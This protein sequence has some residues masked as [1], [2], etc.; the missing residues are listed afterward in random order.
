M[1][2]I[3]QPFVVT[4]Q[5]QQPVT[6]FVNGSVL[7]VSAISAT[8]K[9]ALSANSTRKK[10]LFHNPNTDAGLNNNLLIYPVKDM[11]GATLAPTFAA[12]GGGFVIFPGA[13]LEVS[14]VGSV[15]TAWSV[16]ASAGTLN[17]LTMFIQ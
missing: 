13:S 6:T 17:G 16:L 14:G 15:G 3:P 8:P 9:A 2:D 11:N 12:P 1:T 4:E 10:I 5:Q 7:A